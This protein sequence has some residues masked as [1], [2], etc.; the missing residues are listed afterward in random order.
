MSSVLS[1]EQSHHE[2]M[3][4]PTVNQVYLLLLDINYL[5]FLDKKIADMKGRFNKQNAKARPVI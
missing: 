2:I 3:L 1:I 5:L 4:S